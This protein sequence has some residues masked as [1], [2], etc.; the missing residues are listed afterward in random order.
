MRRM[1]KKSTG[2]TAHRKSDQHEPRRLRADGQR[3]L[4]AVIRAAMEV[5]AESGVDAPVREIAERAGVGPGTMYRHFPQRANLI[6]AVFA[7]EVDA[8]ADAAADIAN[9][10]APGEALALWMQRY[11]DLIATQRGLAAALHSPDPAYAALADHFSTRLEP[12]LGSLLDAAVA[13]GAV[14]PGMDAVE[15]LRA[16]ATLCR[17][18]HD[19]ERA[20]AR[21]MVRLLVDGLRR[22]QTKLRVARPVG[23][24][25]RTESMYCAALGLVVLTRF[26]NHQGFDGVML[27]RP[28]TDY[29]FEFT[30]CREHPMAASPTHEDLLV[31][32]VPERQAWEA[33][34]E[35]LAGH[36]FVRVASFNPYWDVSGRTFED[37]DGYRLVIQNAAWP[38]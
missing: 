37:P 1:K 33:T 17:G 12:A 28:G 25:A 20:F 18:P 31:F 24:I 32:Y 30:R 9:G 35:R 38:S 34:C 10:R 7:A 23:D 21:K 4:D 14:R 29:H 5:F 2:Q 6:A 22:P 15:L 26:E 16:A 19:E 13:A 36:G 8:C 27:G 3:S 11:V